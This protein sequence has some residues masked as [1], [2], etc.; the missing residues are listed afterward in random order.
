M[1][2]VP[3]WKNKNLRCHIC[4]KTRS[5]KYT[6]EIFDPV[7]DNKPTIVYA[8]NKCAL[9]YNDKAIKKSDEV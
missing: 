8:C 9:R 3:D 2:L 7:V 4:G 5:V 1:K 6:I